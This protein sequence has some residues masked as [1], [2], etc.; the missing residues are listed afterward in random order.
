MERILITGSSGFVGRNLTKYLAEEYEILMPNR[1][2]LQD[3]KLD[4][5]AI[6]HL[7]GKAHDIKRVSDPEEYFK[8]NFELTRNLYDKFLRSRAT[9]FI[10][11]SSVKASADEV[12]TVLSEDQLPSPETPYGKSKLLAETYI[13]NQRL[14]TG[15]TF[16]ILRPC[17]IHGQGNKGNL[18]LLFSLIAKGVPYP[19]AAFNNK[20]SFLT[21]ENLCFVI[22]EFIR[23]KNVSSG[24]YNVAD[25]MPLSTNELIQL[26]GQA[27]NKKV[28]LWSI[29]P[30]LVRTICK[31]GDKFHLP[32]TSE[33][34]HK[35]TE[36]Y[37]VSNKKLK[38]A[39]MK[40]LPVDSKQGIISTIKSFTKGNSK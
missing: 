21:A 24:I 29:S 35:L 3:L 15:K 32:L 5:D 8:V 4:C 19:L 6:V 26:I 33:R 7:A 11:V 38:K 2:E 12:S 13:L 20:R 10:F 22:R 39:L 25:D 37:V 31:I 16:Y 34:L 14:P 1:V 27:L 17:M 28:R 9:I 36:S 40:E 23:K 18:N 30:A